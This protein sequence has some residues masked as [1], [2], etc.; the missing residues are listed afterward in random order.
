MINGR[1]VLGQDEVIPFLA[2]YVRPM[3]NTLLG[4][5]FTTV[6]G[7]W[8]RV[9]NSIEDV[10][11]FIYELASRYKWKSINKRMFDSGVPGAERLGLNTVQ[12]I[13]TAYNE[14]EDTR[15]A[16]D[17]AWEGFKL[18]AS[19]NS[20]KAVAKIDEKDRQRRRDELDQHQRKL[21]QFFYTKIGI[22]QLSGKS[23]VAT[24]SHRLAT[25]SVE[26]LEDEMRRWVTG[27]ADLHDRVVEEYKDKIRAQHEQVRVEREARRM[28]LQMERDR[29]DREAQEGDFK[30]QPLL[31][32]TG[33][34][35]QQMLQ[36]RGGR[37]GVA[38]IPAAP[39]ADR[40]YQK[41]LA[42]GAV[43][44]GNL[45][46]TGDKVRDPEANPEADKRTLNQLIKGRNPAFGSGG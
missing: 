12:R 42:E 1:S 14:M 5:L 15:R 2:E 9:G 34:Q 39:N 25:K 4:V 36:G 26:D 17:T 21:D 7:L 27:D 18:V 19:S 37:S 44:G 30:P 24:T 8:T 10:E 33:E 20:P 35:L 31:A 11:V 46:V 40:L 43:T 45:Q 38:F 32:L 22:I 13:W 16:D 41:Y 29:L 28:A 3:P 6:L 23:A